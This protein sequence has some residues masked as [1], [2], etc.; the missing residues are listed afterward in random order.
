VIAIDQLE[1]LA[2]ILHEERIQGAQ[3]HRRERTH[4]PLPL[5]GA[6]QGS[7]PGRLLRRMIAQLLSR[8]AARLGRTNLAGEPTSSQTA[9]TL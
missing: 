3:A 2:R 4:A 5:P 9:S 1:Q 8:T 6:R 7:T